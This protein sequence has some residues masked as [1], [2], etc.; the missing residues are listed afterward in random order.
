MNLNRTLGP[1]ALLAL[2]TATSPLHAQDAY[3]RVVDVGNGLCVVGRVPGGGGFIYDGGYRSDQCVKAVREILPD[4]RI[5]ALM[6]SHSDADHIGEVPE[7]LAINGLRVGT[8]FHP[9]GQ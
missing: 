9:G 2:V 5:D 3:V 1:I 6:L 7:I 4:G 8:I